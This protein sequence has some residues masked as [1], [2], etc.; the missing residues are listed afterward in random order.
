MAWLK[1]KH[2]EA[3]KRN[4]IKIEVEKGKK[5]MMMNKFIMKRKYGL[6]NL[7]AK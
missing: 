1:L 7:Q 2:K 3:T 6:H 4:A 5:K